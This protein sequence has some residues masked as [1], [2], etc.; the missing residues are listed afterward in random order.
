MVR[1]FTLLA[2]MLST[3]LLIGLSLVSATGNAEDA[4]NFDLLEL[5]VKGN[6][7]LENEQIE[8][9]VY[10]YLGA[11]KNLDV[12]EKA[13]AALEALYQVKGYQTV[14][15]DIPE[16]D[17]VNGIVTLQ[18]TEGKV[19]KL[20]VIDSHYFSLGRI[21]SKVSELAEGNVPN[22]AHMQQQLAELAKESPDRQITPILRAGETPGT[23]EVDL[24]VKDEFPL[25][26]KVEV[27]GRN[28]LNTSRLRMIA[29]LRYDNLWQKFHSASFMYQTSPE[30]SDEVEVIVGSYVLPVFESA[31]RL[32]LYAV[33]SSSNSQIAQAGALSVI[34]TGDIYGMRLVHPLPGL[35]NYFHTFTVG[36][37]YK[38]FKEDLALLGSDSIKTPISYLPFLLQYSG[39]FRTK[40]S[41]LSYNL[42]L[43]FSVRNLGNKEQQFADKRFLARSNYMYLAAGFDYK[44][45]L[46]WGMEI[47]T[48]LAGQVSDSPL[49]SNEQFSMGGA[50]SVRG[51]FE[52]Q[53]LSDDGLSGSVELYSPELSPIKWEFVDKLRGLVFLDAGKGWIKNALPG[54]ARQFELAS[55]GVGF[56]LQMMKYLVGE[57]DFAV[58]F[59]SNG[60]VNSG[61]GRAH[62]R[63]ATEF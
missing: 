63:V 43:N 22:M 36:V 61:D 62:F 38:D 29:Q 59:I 33:S 56:R 3:L 21:K 13:R 16:Q 48:S 28:T 14:T 31:T 44:Y 5:R 32:A 41:L 9:L 34:G 40:A 54:N 10:P 11:S 35:N 4:N 2:P 46:P 52:T 47:A 18:V 1:M 24:K 42:D 27:N 17:V 15:V 25:H 53:S 19:S 7:Q 45:N 49:I 37:D 20:R 55:A 12:V 51:Y 60:S 57:F 26:G 58:P 8:R 30:N 23:L 6:T 39:N 50:Q